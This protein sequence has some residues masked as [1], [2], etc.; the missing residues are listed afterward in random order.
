MIEQDKTTVYNNAQAVPLP[1]NTRAYLPAGAHLL[2]DLH[3]VQAVLLADGRQLERVLKEAALAA[4]ATILSSHFHRFGTGQGVTGVVL[5][6]ESHISIHTWPEAGFAA[7]DLFMCGSAQVHEALALIS[8][9][10]ACAH[11][12]STSV[13]RGSLPRP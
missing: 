1:G 5:L 12:K 3:G 11:C 6:A 7:V 10:L 9:A 2:A 13:Q 8:R 4:G